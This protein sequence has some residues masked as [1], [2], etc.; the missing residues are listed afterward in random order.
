MTNTGN[1]A[2]ETSSVCIITLTFLG[3]TFKPPNFQKKET[4]TASAKQQT[5]TISSFTPYM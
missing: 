4:K 5:L 3:V 2:T 1:I